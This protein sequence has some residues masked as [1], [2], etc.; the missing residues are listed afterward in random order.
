MF[1]VADCS[2][3]LSCD[4]DGCGL[5]TVVDDVAEEIDYSAGAVNDGFEIKTSCDEDGCGAVA[6]VGDGRADATS[7]GNTVGVIVNNIQIEM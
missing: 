3:I 4:D 1:G 2:E 7:V 5:Q 6:V